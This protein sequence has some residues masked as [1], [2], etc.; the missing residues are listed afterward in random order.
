MHS[1]FLHVCTGIH[2]V[3]CHL[4]GC[5]PT[6][7]ACP[8]PHHMDCYGW[9]ESWSTG[10]NATNTL[11]LCC[12]SKSQVSGNG[13]LRWME[14]KWLSFVYNSES[15]LKMSKLIQTE[16]TVDELTLGTVLLWHHPCCPSWRPPF[17]MQRTRL[18][19][20]CLSLPTTAPAGTLQYERSSYNIHFVFFFLCNE[21]IWPSGMVLG[22]Q[23]QIWFHFTLPLF[24][25]VV[26]HRHST[27]YND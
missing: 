16:D 15:L 2:S 19:C 26:C 22:W 25:K 9:K 11:Q 23:T 7:K 17:P 8:L 20:H 4:G 6:S 5:I 24:A 27:L 21:P 12:C 3:P 10:V 1:C 14:D 18:T 13:G